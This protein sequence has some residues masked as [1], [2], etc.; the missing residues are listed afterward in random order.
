MVYDHEKVE[1]LYHFDIRQNEYLQCLPQKF[2]KELLLLHLLYF[3][4]LSL[5]VIYLLT[6][7]YGIVFE[8]V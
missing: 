2:F 6:F 7:N 8:L 1:L 3:R 4:Y 5:I